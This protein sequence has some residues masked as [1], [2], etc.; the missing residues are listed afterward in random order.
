MATPRQ[1][2]TMRESVGTDTVTPGCNE[3]GCGSTGAGMVTPTSYK[4]AL[5]RDASANVRQ[6]V[7]REAT[8]RMLKRGQQQI[9]AE[10]IAGGLKTCTGVE[11]LVVLL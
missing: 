3:P 10:G 11:P 5:M 1:R 8:T 4:E 6:R 9:P 2:T 7:G